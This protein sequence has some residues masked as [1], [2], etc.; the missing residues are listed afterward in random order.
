MKKFLTAA[1]TSVLFAVSAMAQFESA[2]AFPGAEGFARYTTKGGR[3]GAVYHVTKLTDDGSEGTLRWA[4][5]KSGKRTI[6]FDVSGTIYLKSA[7]SIKNGWVSIL[8]QTAP[9]DGICIA[10]YPFTIAAQNV[11]LRFLRFRL[12]NRN[13]AN[14]EG[15]GLGGMDQANIIVDH[16]SVSWS[17]DEC[18]SVYGSKN[19]SI[20]WNFVDQSM[21]NSGHS[22]GAHGYGGNWGGSGAS[23]HHNLIA[24][25]TS[26]TPRLGP[27]PG[28][29]CDERMDLRNNVMYNWGGNGCYGGEGMNVNIVNNYYKP[30][31]ATG[32][33][34]GKRIAKVNIRT[35][36]YCERKVD[37]NGNVTG[38][39][40]LPMWHVWG[41]YYVN[42]NVNSKYDEV[43]KDNW[44][45]GFINQI[46]ANGNDGTFTSVT[47]DT[48]KLTQPIAYGTI[49][50][51][52]AENAYAMVVKYAG[53]SL[54]RDSHDKYIADDVT[55]G[56]AKYTGSGL[57]TGFINSQ[58]DAGGWPELT[59]E[60]AP[61]DTDRDGMPDAWETA[62]GLNPNDASDSKL[63]NLDS[64][65]YYTN[66]EVYCNELVE[67]IVKAES[68]NSD[69]T[70]DGYFEEYYPDYKDGEG[71][72][73]DS[74]SDSGSSDSGQATT[75]N[76]WDF[77]R[78][79]VTTDNLASDSQWTADGGN[80]T[81]SGTLTAEQLAA[82]GKTISEAAGLIITAPANSVVF[83]STSIRF[84]KAGSTIVIPSLAKGD[85]VLVTWK[86]ANSSAE[87]GFETTNLSEVA[88]MTTAQTTAS[89][90]VE[91]D[92]DVTLSVSGGIYVYSI[93]VQRKG[94]DGI[95]ELPAASNGRQT[96]TYNL[97]GMQV[98]PLYKGIVIH[99]GR[100]YT[101]K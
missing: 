57:S 56:V 75:L 14:H 11:I 85:I 47:R 82:N 51:Q 77:T 49:R 84:N 6:V 7:L 37:A 28:T 39:G 92:G 53:A 1:I 5:S 65:R 52:T 64:H 46:D 88:L 76:K 30:G 96:A 33:S 32:S 86:S 8:G 100:K 40:W 61:T 59:S 60:A 43:T 20:Q 45:Q 4:I 31:P 94:A 99:N 48:I 68:E 66:L 42:G 58:D 16:C 27:R 2:P 10:D 18:L 35:T 9:G 21:V 67:D 19:I 26:R 80:Y 95:V 90:T 24:H 29:Q 69:K 98:S 81:Y 83:Y 70:V 12:G 54:H 74:G 13:V 41:H 89:A 36:E 87:R 71:V 73:P 44:G 50:T 38:N 15:D 23:Y 91:A 3:E 63:Y 17:V 93:E 55:N 78:S 22:K 25:H 34:V 101:N 62:H 97:S 79:E 72:T